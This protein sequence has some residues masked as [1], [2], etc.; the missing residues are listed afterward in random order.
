M[1]AN[2][3]EPTPTLDSYW[4]SI[5]LIGNNVA[6]YKFALAQSLFE[7]GEK[8]ASFITLEELAIPFS[9]NICAH[10]KIKDKQGTS[11]SSQFLDACRKFNNHEITNEVLVDSTARLGFANVVNAFHVVS[12]ENIKIQFFIDDRKTKKGITITDDFFKLKELFQYQN[13]PRETEARWNLVE[14]AWSQNLNPALLEIVNDSSTNNLFRRSDSLRRGI[15]SS[16]DALNGYQRGKCFYSFSDISILTGSEILADVDHFFPY[17]LKNKLKGLNLDGV[18]NLVLASKDCNRG[19]SGKFD[20]IPDRKYLKRLHRRNSYLINSHHP[21]RE[22]L[23]LQTGRT[24]DQR[25]HFLKEAYARAINAN[26]TTWRAP[27]E[28]EPQF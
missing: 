5:I 20:K 26:P 17:S 2:F 15:T 19:E 27:L 9:R 18:W 6:S 21:L 28:L 24:D 14:T 4:R 3:N 22:S 7:V 1:N 10:L 25:Q 16:R 8:D 12:Q 13:L 11:S 23:I